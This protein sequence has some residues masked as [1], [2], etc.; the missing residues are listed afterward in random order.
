MRISFIFSRFIIV[1]RTK[2]GT[3]LHDAAPR[4]SSPPI[5]P[6]AV[7]R[8]ASATIWV[9]GDVIVVLVFPHSSSIVR[10]TS[11]PLRTRSN[12]EFL[13]FF[14]IRIT[15]ISVKYGLQSPL[16]SESL[17]VKTFVGFCGRFRLFA[18]VVRP[19]CAENVLCRGIYPINTRYTS[20][21]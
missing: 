21:F 5:S 17:N 20:I 2:S 10:L 8:S 4:R 19:S 18:F 12:L 14:K 6:V 16:Q 11:V 3:R 9:Y 7:S 1:F 15:S 13:R